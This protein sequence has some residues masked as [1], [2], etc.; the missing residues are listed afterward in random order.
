VNRQDNHGNSFEITT[1][2]RTVTLFD[3]HKKHGNSESRSSI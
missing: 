1:I 3:I 2:I